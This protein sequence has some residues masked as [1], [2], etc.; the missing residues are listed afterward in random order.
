[1][2]V[3]GGASSAVGLA[4]A[5]VSVL[6]GCTRALATAA[7]RF[8]DTI[9]PATTRTTVAADRA[10]RVVVAVDDVSAAIA[11][12]FPFFSALG[13]VVGLSA[14]TD[15][16]FDLAFLGVTGDAVGDSVG[17]VV[18]LAVGDVVGDAVG[19]CVGLGVGDVVGD[20]VGDLV[21]DAVGL[22][23]GLVVGDVVGDV[24][25]LV[26][27]DVV[28]DVVGLVVGDA[29]GDVVGLS[30]QVGWKTSD[31]IWA[32]VPLRPSLIASTSLSAKV[33]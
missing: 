25:G 5:S 15:L 3:G 10:T 9:T 20:A 21:G 8:F 2:Y 32:T 19:D 7:C 14:F 27:G 13:G 16:A 24:V 6:K 12:F 4:L 11:L 1:L 28:G 30:V 23:V 33:K 22:V 29:V 26:V 18:G 17:D 31:S